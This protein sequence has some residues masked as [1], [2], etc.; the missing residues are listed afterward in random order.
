MGLCK[1]NATCIFMNWILVFLFKPQDHSTRWLDDWQN[2]YINCSLL[3]KL[4]L[5]YKFK[6]IHTSSNKEFQLC[7]CWVVLFC[8]YH[9]MALKCRRNFK[10]LASKPL[11]TGSHTSYPFSLKALSLPSALSQQ[12]SKAQSKRRNEFVFTAQHPHITPPQ[13]IY[14]TWH[15]GGEEPL[16][17]P[18]V[19]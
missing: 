5:K 12:N 14:C 18:S 13:P 1:S 16:C 17:L 9:Q 7:S 10:H 4:L 15:T 8:F 2:W 19:A 3:R 6:L 11:P